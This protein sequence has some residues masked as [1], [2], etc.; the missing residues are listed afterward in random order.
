MGYLVPI[1]YYSSFHQ[2]VAV[3]VVVVVQ[4]AS[5]AELVEA[6]DGET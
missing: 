2:L 5:M 4:N 1:Y 3:V 6:G